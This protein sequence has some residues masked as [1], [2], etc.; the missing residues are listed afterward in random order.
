M[1]I[2]RPELSWRVLFPSQGD[3]LCLQRLALRCGY[4][5]TELST[6][7]ECT[8]RYLHVVFLRDIGLTPKEWMRRERMVVA[9]RM[10]AGGRVPEE[11]AMDLGFATQ[12]NFRRE[13]LETYRVLPLQFQRERWLW[14]SR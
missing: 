6:E 2:V 1:R 4:R 9:R 3:S 8:R 13:F 12:N 7:L 5:V 14:D 10:L 11:V